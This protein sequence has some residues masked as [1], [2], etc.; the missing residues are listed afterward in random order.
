M[1]DV[2]KAFEGKLLNCLKEYNGTVF[3]TR[4]MFLPKVHN[5]FCTWLKKT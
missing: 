3:K 2:N 4:N 5:A 1:L